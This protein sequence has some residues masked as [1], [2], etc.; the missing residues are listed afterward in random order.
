MNEPLISARGISRSF[1]AGDETITVLRD[2]DVDIRSGEMV[3]IIGASGSGKSTL[4]NILG[5]LDRASSGSYS[6]AG[7]DVSELGPDQLSQL[8]R[9]HF[10]FIFQRYQLLSDLDAVGNVEVPAIYAGESRADRHKRAS[11]LLGQLGLADRLDHRP[12]ELSG[13]QQ[14]R[15][16]VARA[17]MNGG[18]VILADEPTG[19]LDTKSSKEMI[20]LLLE[21][22]RKGHT[23]VMVTHDPEV[24]LHAHRTIEIS[25]GRII[26]DTQAAANDV[27]D[28]NRLEHAPRKTGTGAALLRL[29]EAFEMSFKALLAHRVRSVLTM[30]GII[31]GI[32][33]VVLVVA[34]GTGTKEKVLDSIS[35]LGTSTITVRSGTGF[36]ARNAAKVET[37]VPSD[38]D[39]L[40]LQPYADS[41][42]PSVATQRNVVYSGTASDASINGVSGDYF[43]V[44]NYNTLTGS[45]FASDDVIDRSQVAVIDEDTRDT[46][47]DASDDPVGKVLLL[48]GVP[49]RVIGVVR[50][51]GAS[52]GPESLN[53]WV[54]YTT[55]MT[56]ISG[57]NFLDSIEV[58]VSD[59]YDTSFAET[60]INA[61][62][63][64]RHGTKDFFLTNSDTIRDTMTSTTETLTLLVSMI[65]VISLIVGGIG[66]MNIMLVSVTERTKEIGVRIAI[67]ARRSDIVAQFLIEA[68][69]VCLT[70]G[71]IGIAGALIGGQMVVYFSTDVQLSFSA[72][73]IV[74]AFLSSTLIGITFGYLPARAAARLD[75]VVALNHA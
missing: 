4:M 34:L 44:H 27:K 55:V 62:L 41:T 75:P 25:D 74:V 14:Q 45:T 2:V 37:L 17:L 51:S 56:R 42:S 12:G 5:C 59:D 19:A 64:T 66:V 65:A 15:V 24:A 28:A 30:L 67:G 38:S 60:E 50:S 43:Q 29:R 46:F 72:T 10:G 73:A 39:A 18:E 1:Q 71:V 13:G 36:G 9:E 48:G 11:D 32:A 57:Q 35:S 8:R 3:A 7:Q 68:V 6:F 40:A 69:L 58:R 53:V 52:F 21:L 70:G 54:P 49:V 47:F 63:T 61:L 16:S 33:S 22:N 26:S 31:I 20:D 23:I